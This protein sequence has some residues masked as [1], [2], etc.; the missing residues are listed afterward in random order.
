MDILSL[1]HEVHLEIGRHLAPVSRAQAGLCNLQVHP[2]EQSRKHADSFAQVF[3]D[4]IWLT[5]S[6]S[7]GSRP[8]LIGIDL[9]QIYHEE[10]AE[11]YLLLI[12]EDVLD[13]LHGLRQSLRDHDWDEDACQAR[14][15]H[16]QIALE[17]ATCYC[18]SFL[19]DLCRLY[20]ESEGWMKLYREDNR[21][22]HSAM[23]HYTD[24][25]GALHRFS[26]PASLLRDSSQLY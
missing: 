13:D 10:K 25:K 11:G 4:D 24:E 5:M 3:K 23:L 16:C 8:T 14:M 21:G 9:V 26:Q 18:H 19:Q 20:D 17:I 22:I 15:R 6:T 7:A 2:S 12:A 1:P